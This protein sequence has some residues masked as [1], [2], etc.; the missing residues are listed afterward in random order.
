MCVCNTFHFHFFCCLTLPL[1]KKLLGSK[2]KAINIYFAFIFKFCYAI[3]SKVTVVRIFQKWFSQIFIYVYLNIVSQMAI[4]MLLTQGKRTL[5][6][7]EKYRDPGQVIT[8]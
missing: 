4:R 6:E 2:R 7:I 1:R 3:Q 5:R 8:S